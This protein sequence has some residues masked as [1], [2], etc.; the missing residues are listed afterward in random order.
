MF[1]LEIDLFILSHLGS[2]DAEFDSLLDQVEV[3]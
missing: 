3:A 2:G 1:D